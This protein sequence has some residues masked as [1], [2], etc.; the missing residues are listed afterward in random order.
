MPIVPSM[1]DIIKK[2]KVELLEGN[3]SERNSDLK[4]LFDGLGT[5]SLHDA[6]DSLKSLQDQVDQLQL[7]L[8]IA[9]TTSKRSHKQIRKVLTRL[10]R[11]FETKKG[12]V[13][14]LKAQVSQL[15]G[16][17]ADANN[18]FQ[19]AQKH[20]AEL[21]LQHSELQPQAAL[22]VRYLKGEDDREEQ[23]SLHDHRRRELEDELAAQR[24]VIS[25]RD[26]D[27][28][29]LQREV[30]KLQRMVD[31]LGASQREKDDAILRLRGQIAEGKTSL[32]RETNALKQDHDWLV[33]QLK[34]K[35]QELVLTN[36]TTAEALASAEAR[37]KALAPKSQQLVVEREQLVAMIE[38]IGYEVE[39]QRQLM[40][41]RLKAMSLASETS[42]YNQIEETRTQFE[43]EKRKIYASVA[44]HFRQFYDARKELDDEEF[45][46]IVEKVVEEIARMKAQDLNIRRLLGLELNEPPENAISSLIFAACHR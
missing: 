40:N 44:K 34:A 38:S 35:Q 20:V 29:A 43:V 21:E 26:A 10:S 28:E 24:L 37:V 45:E 31:L 7:E 22:A 2:S 13:E 1:S 32:E 16:E 14:S 36:Q 19:A 27:I 42:C 23:A 15:M 3:L 46:K 17:K 4:V 8:S 30:G 6:N 39:R 33:H 18:R 9:H 11:E 5:S 12:E 41:T 25:T